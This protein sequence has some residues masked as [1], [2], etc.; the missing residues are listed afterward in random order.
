MKPFLSIEDACQFKH[1]SAI[2][3][4][5]AAGA[6]LEGP[7]VAKLLREDSEGL[8]SDLAAAV[9]KY[10]M[11]ALPDQDLTLDELSATCSLLGSLAEMPFL[12]SLPGSP[13]LARVVREPSES[14]L[15]GFGGGWHADWSFQ[16]QPPELAMLY[17]QELP[18]SGG[19]TV[20]SNQI[21]AWRNLSQGFRDSIRNGRGL[22][23]ARNSYST[24][25]AYARG[26]DKTSMEI[27]ISDDALRVTP[28]SVVRTHRKTGDEA[29]F[30]NDAYTIALEIDGWHSHEAMSILDFL[31]RWSKLDEFVFRFHWTPRTLV[32][33]DNHV[34]NHRSVA[35]YDGS[36]RE[37]IRANIA[38]A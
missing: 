24:A 27:V 17:S 7:P 26:A 1:Y 33:W 16:P 23:S 31:F 22:H 11:I 19:D 21:L 12:R 3:I 36:R 28:H 14:G 5:T 30:V 15:F 2:P 20:F 37:L 32:F 10:L 25:S 9:G 13:G 18:L 38:L 34:M 29:L 4:G 35:D 8:R 6:R